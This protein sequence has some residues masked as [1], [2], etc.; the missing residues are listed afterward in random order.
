VF[1]LL[2][3]L[4]FVPPL[5]VLMLPLLF[6]VLIVHVGFVPLLQPVPVSLILPLVPIVIVPTVRIV[7]PVLPFFLLMPLMIILGPRYG[8]SPDGCHQRRR[9]AKN[10]QML[11]FRTHAFP[12]D[13]PEYDAFLPQPVGVIE[14]VVCMYKA[15]TTKL[16]FPK[17]GVRSG[18]ASLDILSGSSAVS[19]V[20]LFVVV[21]RQSQ[22]QISE[23]SGNSIAKLFALGNQAEH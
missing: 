13:V 4:V 11:H 10:C 16:R 23:H 18:T 5:P 7:N 1:V 20:T 8:E 6:Q 12:P 21:R 22:V 15:R 9:Q 14:I 17:D 19:E 2:V 3:L